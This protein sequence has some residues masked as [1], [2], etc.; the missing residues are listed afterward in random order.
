MSEDKINLLASLFGGKVGSMPFTYLGLPLGTTRPT[1]QDFSPLVDRVERR[2]S[3][4]ATFLSYGDKLTMIN[5]ILSHLPIYYMCSLKLPK[6][7]IDHIDRARKHCLWRGSSDFNARCNSLAA[8][9]KVCKPKK[10]RRARGL[11]PTNAKPSP[12]YE[13]FAQ[14]L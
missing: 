7:V 5:S 4:S 11:E 1:M 12:S 14:I 9:E 2:L 3:S 8:F 13:T 10:K 6:T